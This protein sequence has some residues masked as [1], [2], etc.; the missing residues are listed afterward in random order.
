MA[1]IPFEVCQTMLAEADQ[2]YARGQREEAAKRYQWVA[3]Q[4]EDAV[5][6]EQRA[7][8][9]VATVIGGALGFLIP[10]GHII[11]VPAAAWAGY[12]LSKGKIAGMAEN[13][14]YGAYYR[15]A[16]QGLL[17]CNPR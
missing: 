1:Q 11:T 2:L 15:R 7:F 10:L 6:S 16:L 5:N 13:Q 9:G 4:I 8:T 3:E 12:K 17:N 14:E